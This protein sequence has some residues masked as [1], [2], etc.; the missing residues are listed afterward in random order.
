MAKI[1]FDEVKELQAVN[2]FK[3][4]GLWYGDPYF[5]IECLNTPITQRE[6]V[7]HL[8]A[9]EETEWFPNLINDQL[10]VT[11]VCV[12]D[13]DASGMVGGID[14]FG[15]KWVALENG[16]PAMVK[17]GNP[18]LKDI[19]DW[20]ELIWPDIDSWDWEGVGKAFLDSIDER[21]MVRGIMLSTYFERLIALMDFENAAMALI[22]DPESV[23]EF[24][25]KLTEYNISIVD[26]YI[27]YFHVDAIMAH[28]DWSAQR[29][30]FFSEKIARDLILPHLKK[31]VQHCH[32]KG[33]YFTLHS[34]GN[35]RK[36]APV[37]IEA[38]IDGWQL[39][40]NAMDIEELIDLFGDKIVLEASLMVPDNDEEAKEY[41]S[42]MVKV[43]SRTKKPAMN[44]YDM[45]FTRGFDSH[46]YIY[47]N[48]RKAAL[49]KSYD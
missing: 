43:M 34:C 11:P 42:K 10:D 13:V 22:E 28:D 25:E 26:H 3:P 17:P 37:M 32:D 8:Y 27:K 29:S 1:A 49:A 33:L 47:T 19:A 5:P 24:F 6:N 23:T 36:L 18:L 2:I 44:F 41:I 40:E 31:L 21:R 39:Q 38:G 45:S 9:G 46:K 7:R 15:V 48:M 4:E 20:R 14:S 12:P 35:G 30:P 16:L